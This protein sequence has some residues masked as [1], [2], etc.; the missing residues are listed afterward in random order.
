MDKIFQ[1]LAVFALIMLLVSRSIRG[2][3]P[4]YNPFDF[5]RRF[6]PPLPAEV[7]A[8]LKPATPGA[9]GELEADMFV[10]DEGLAFCYSAVGR[11]VIY[12]WE[13]QKYRQKQELAVPLDCVAMAFDPIDGKLYFESGGYIF[14]YGD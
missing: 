3:E 14:Q 8:R 5:I 2:R 1:I 7:E 13:R 11:L 4:R 12:R 10:I 6:Q 9:A